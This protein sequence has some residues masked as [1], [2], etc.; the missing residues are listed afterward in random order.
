MSAHANCST[1][2]GFTAGNQDI[3]YALVAK[4]IIQ[5]VEKFDVK[6]VATSEETTPHA[7]CNA[8][9]LFEFTTD[10]TKQLKN[11]G[12]HAHSPAAEHCRHVHHHLGNDFLTTLLEYRG[13]PE[14]PAAREH[15]TLVGTK[16]DPIPDNNIRRVLHEAIRSLSKGALESKTD[17]DTKCVV[18]GLKG[19]SDYH[20]EGRFQ[21]G[22][23][24]GQ[25]GQHGQRSRR[26]QYGTERAGGRS[27][28]RGQA[29]DFRN[30]DPRTSGW[31][32]FHNHVDENDRSANAAA[33]TRIEAEMEAKKAEGFKPSTTYKKT[34]IVDGVRTL[35]QVST[36]GEV[37]GGGVALPQQESGVHFRGGANLPANYVPPHK[38]GK[39]SVD[40]K[41]GEGGT[42]I[43]PTLPQNMPDR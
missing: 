37:S 43:D 14:Q 33:K 13:E 38:R 8:L 7:R 29:R 4:V 19:F 42:R 21:R 20:R 31:H 17:Q 16:S 25:R 23:G 10:L 2:F 3:H 41:I 27:R 1:Q 22:S 24:R 26:G 5:I 36:N 34:V 9:A 18:V 6:H 12:I 11:A 28:G 15:T 40:I 35:V 39:V 30:S 32:T